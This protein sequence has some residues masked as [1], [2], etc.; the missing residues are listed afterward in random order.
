MLVKESAS[1][2]VDVTLSGGPAIIPAA[3]RPAEADLFLHLKDA[4]ANPTPIPG[5]PQ[6]LLIGD[7]ISIGYT[8]PVRQQLEGKALVFRPSVNCQHTGY[9]LAQLKTWLGTNRWEVI[10]FNWG[11]WDTHL[12]DKAGELVYDE[13]ASASTGLFHI[14]YTPEQY[15]D[16]LSRLVDMLQ[17][18][19]ARLIW[20]SSTPIMSRKGTRFDDVKILNAVAAGIMQDRHIEIDD[21]Y[22][23]VLPHVQTWQCPDQVHFNEIGNAKL[24]EKVTEC[25]RRTV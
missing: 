9:G 25:V 13:R 7:S 24:G 2:A 18:T 14:R 6:V 16:N 19:E 21:L 20:A 12:L 1:L 11:I 4:C 3:L 5:L 23:F 15:H 8:V 22:D 17:A 10:H